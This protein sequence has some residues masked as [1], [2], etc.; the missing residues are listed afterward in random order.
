MTILIYCP[1]ARVREAISRHLIEAGAHQ[2]L[3][4]ESEKL[5][6]SI[7]LDNEIKLV[8]LHDPAHIRSMVDLKDF[9]RSKRRHMRVRILP[10][11]YGLLLEGWRD[12][13]NDALKPIKAR[14]PSELGTHPRFKWKPNN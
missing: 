2:L 3:F 13:I 4:A 11:R 9:L 10:S 14:Q 1:G 5:V 8:L 6:V 7:A 12:V